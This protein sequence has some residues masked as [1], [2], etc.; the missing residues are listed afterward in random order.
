SHLSR[1]ETGADTASDDL[2]MRVATELGADPDELLLSAGRIPADLLQ[3]MS[4]QPTLALQFL[5][6]LRER[7]LGRRGDQEA[8]TALRSPTG[9][10]RPILAADRDGMVLAPSDAVLRTPKTAESVA[11]RIIHDIVERHARPGDH[12]ASEA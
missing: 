8:Q 4:D 7:E 3:R 2:L 6:R 5:K 9:L 10:A 1:I 11:R 12:L